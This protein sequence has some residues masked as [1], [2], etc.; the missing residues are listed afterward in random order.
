MYH[1]LYLHLVWTTRDREPLIDA[2]V[3]AFI[4]RTLRSVA[5]KERGYILEIGMV[6]THVHVLMRVHPTVTISRMVQ[7]LKSLSSTMA[8]RE[9]LSDV[10]APLY[11]AK[12][13]S[14]NSVSPPNLGIVRGY[15]RRQPIHHSAEAIVGWPGDTEAEYDAASPLDLSSDLTM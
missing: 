3:A 4:C 11:R 15:L 2:G 10:G 7:R 13:Y 14:V 9:H 8:N 5:R 6:R 12:G 1:R